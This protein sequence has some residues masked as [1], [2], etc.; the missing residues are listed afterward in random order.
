MLNMKTNIFKILNLNNFNTKLVPEKLH[1]DTRKSH[2][3]I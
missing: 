3:P 1:T 2:G